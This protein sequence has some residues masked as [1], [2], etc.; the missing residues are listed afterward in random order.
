MEARTREAKS[1]A[2]NSRV[3]QVVVT[4]DDLMAAMNMASL[5]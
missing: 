5:A 3:Y 4:H 1:L 2:T